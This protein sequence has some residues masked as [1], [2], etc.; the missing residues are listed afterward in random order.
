MTNK[1]RYIKQEA[2]PFP[3]PI[4]GFACGPVGT[5]PFCCKLDAVEFVGIIPLGIIPFC[6]CTA[7]HYA[8]S[9]LTDAR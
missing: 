3:V 4:E 2:S 7:H 1:V 6:I 8:L 9:F 5:I